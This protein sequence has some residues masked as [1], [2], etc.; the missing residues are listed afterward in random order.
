MRLRIV[1]GSLFLVAVLALLLRPALP[2]S[3]GEKARDDKGNWTES[4]GDA[5]GNHGADASAAKASERGR[6]RDLLPLGVKLEAD[7]LRG[8]I[9]KGNVRL[10]F[11]N[12]VEVW[13]DQVQVSAGNSAFTADGHVMIMSK[14]RT[15]CM[16]VRGSPVK[17]E[18]EGD[19]WRVKSLSGV[20]L[21]TFKEPQSEEQ[22]RELQMS[23]P[24]LQL[25]KEG[26]ED[27]PE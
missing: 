4:H 7:E 11:P 9:A 21:R 25:G 23:P 27:A 14:G 26:Q 6:L 8:T 17:W 2:G 18:K 24:S 12:D 19:D 22:M 10:S 16:L 13:A 3:A 20:E 5:S 15:N 1:A